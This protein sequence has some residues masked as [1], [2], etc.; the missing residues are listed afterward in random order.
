MN[1][2]FNKIRELFVRS[3][4]EGTL[5]TAIYYPSRGTQLIN[6]HSYDD[7]NNFVTIGLL[8]PGWKTIAAVEAPGKG[9]KNIPIIGKDS[10]AVIDFL[11]SQKDLVN[12]AFKNSFCRLCKTGKERETCSCCKNFDKRTF[13]YVVTNMNK[14]WFNTCG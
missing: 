10:N 5:D 13:D 4:K 7:N 1:Y 12:K 9:V 6:F 11:I 2:T 3:A 8:M 14:Y